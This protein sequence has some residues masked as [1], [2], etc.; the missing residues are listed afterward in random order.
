VNVGLI[1]AIFGTLT[2]GLLEIKFDLLLSKNK[3]LPRSGNIRIATINEAANIATIN[4]STNFEIIY[5]P[6][7]LHRI[8]A[9]I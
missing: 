3:V 1:S 7:L 5:R 9:I 4:T 2:A 8:K 6:K